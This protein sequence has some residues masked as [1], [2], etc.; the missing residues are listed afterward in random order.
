MSQLTFFGNT[1][2]NTKTK[3]V[4]QVSSLSG[5]QT[6]SNTEKTP[7]TPTVPKVRSYT[8]EA[9]FSHSANRTKDTEGADAACVGRSKKAPGKSSAQFSFTPD[10]LEH[11]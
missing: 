9:E 2:I 11:T 8:R 4:F 5:E 1:N 7:D 6:W 3:T 10:V